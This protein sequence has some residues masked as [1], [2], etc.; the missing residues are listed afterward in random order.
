MDR[1]FFMFCDVYCYSGWKST[2]S[3]ASN[4]DFYLILLFWVSLLLCFC[5]SID[6]YSKWKFLLLF[7][8]L[9]NCLW[10]ELFCFWC[11]YV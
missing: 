1:I 11:S 4:W 7:I 9:M 3:S 5:L 8:V 6:I 10:I 2:F